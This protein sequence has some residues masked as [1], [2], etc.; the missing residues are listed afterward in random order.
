MNQ[1]QKFIHNRNFPIFIILLTGLI[2][3][4]IIFQDFG[5]SWDEPDYYRYANDTLSAYSITDRLSGTFNLNNAMG[6]SDLRYYGPAFLIVGEGFHALFSLLFPQALSIDIWHLTIYLSFLMGIFFFYKLAQRWV[7]ITAATISTLLFASQPV[8]FGMSWINPKDIPFMVFFMGAI[9]LGLVF[10]DHAKLAFGKP[11]LEQRNENVL[12]DQKP[13]SQRTA[14]ILSFIGACFLLGFTCATRIIGP[15]AALLVMWIWVVNL[16]RK[17]IPLIAVYGLLSFFIFFIC[18]PYLWQNTLVNLIYV[19]LRMVN[20]PDLHP[21]LFAG[22][23][24]DS[25][26]LPMSYLP[27][28]FIKTLTEP[29]IILILMGLIVIVYRFIKKGINQVEILALLFWFFIPFLYFVITT[30][31]LY[32]NYRQVLF[33]IPAAFLFSAF[34]IDWLCKKISNNW[35]NALIIF[36]VLFPGLL[37]NIQLHPYEYAYYNSIAGGIQGAAHKYD[38]EYWV[39]C[40]KNL[41]EQINS[42]EKGPVNVYVWGQPDVVSFY[43]DKNITVKSFNEAYYTRGSLVVLPL[44]L[45]SELL[46]PSYPIVYSVRLDNVDLCV[47][48]RVQ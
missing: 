17:S 21:V 6:P 41:T 32:D 35:L 22:I 37:A 30:P 15:F 48:R 40:Y 3:G 39:T 20:F 14:L 29:A 11:D 33:I 2:L 47:A 34:S 38:V 13:G 24:Y 18:W 8:L 46:F 28:L 31:P 45:E 16:K 4:L 9:Y 1:I 44:R 10:Y 42:N 43:A 26:A 36:V 5:A 19:I 12:S 25:R 23:I 27:T 7:S